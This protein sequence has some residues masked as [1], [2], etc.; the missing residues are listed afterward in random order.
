MGF[1]IRDG[2]EVVARMHYLNASAEPMTVAPKYEWFTVDEAS[3]QNL[4]GPFIWVF[5]NFEIPPKSELTVTGGCRMPAQMNLVSV[6]PHMHA[7]GTAFTADFLGGPL[8]GQRFLNSTGYD[9]ENGVWT[10]YRP[11]IDLSQGEGARFSCTW[12]NTYDK[13]IVEGIGDNE[14]CMMFGYA[15]PYNN[16]FSTYATGPEQCVTITPPPL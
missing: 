13:T 4:L 15:Y 11:A 10:Q 1:P 14:M 6:L 3:I 12:N 7:L 8:D 16:A 2:Y 9:P 5:K